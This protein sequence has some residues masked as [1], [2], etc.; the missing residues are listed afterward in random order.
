MW[1]IGFS[2]TKPCSKRKNWENRKETVEDM[3]RKKPFTTRRL[4]SNRKANTISPATTS[5][6]HSL[7]STQRQKYL[8]IHF[9]FAIKSH[10]ASVH[11][12]SHPC[13]THAR[14]NINT[15]QRKKTEFLSL[16]ILRVN[17]SHPSDLRD[18]DSEN[19][20]ASEREYSSNR[21]STPVA[22]NGRVREILFCSCSS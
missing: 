17:P 2:Q 18:S 20:N 22:R 8:V 10:R 7:A 6:T 21:W 16:G 9:W 11:P 5:A 1:D 14:R 3:T 4:E 13:A 12:S 19:P 15:G